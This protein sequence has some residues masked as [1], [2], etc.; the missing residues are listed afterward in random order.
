MRTK[1]KEMILEMIDSYN[2]LLYRIYIWQKRINGENSAPKMA[3]CYLPLVM[4]FGSFVVPIFY[5]LNF[6]GI[7]LNKQFL[8][9]IFILF[10]WGYIDYASYN[11]KNIEAKF[12][13]EN[14]I[15]RRQRTKNMW[16]LIIITFLWITLFAILF[17]KPSIDFDTINN[18]REI[19]NSQNQREFNW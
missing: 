12:K 4:I 18:L 15:E 19:R 7:N 1:V 2:Y 17:A 11:M 10:I 6:L 9:I 14:V 8:F 13:D 16:I 3:A 5:T